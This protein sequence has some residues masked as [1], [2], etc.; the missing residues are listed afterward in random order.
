MHSNTSP[1]GI[2]SVRQLAEQAR[3]IGLD[4]IAICDHDSFPKEQFKLKGLLILRGM[5]CSTAEGHLSV[6]GVPPNFDFVKGMPAAEVVARARRAGGISIVNHA[7]SV[8]K[9]R[10]S[11]GSAGLKLGATA[12]ERFNGSDFVH[13]F[14]ALRKIPVG[15]GGSDAHSFYELAN[16]YTILDCRPR[17][18]DVLEEVRKGRMKAVLSQNPFSI[19]KRKYERFFIKRARRKEHQ[20]AGELR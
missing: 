15:T 18:D 10:S 19:L 14:M 1:D 13:N 9:R 16:A 5:E 2:H 7:F 8:R 3:K 12:I 20:H 17:E 4:G 11:M 6:F